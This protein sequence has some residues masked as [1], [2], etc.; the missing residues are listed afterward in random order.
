MDCSVTYL[1][2]KYF[3]DLSKFM[4]ENTIDILYTQVYVKKYA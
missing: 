2:I 1:K 3:K 4:T